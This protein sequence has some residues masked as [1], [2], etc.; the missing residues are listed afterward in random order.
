MDLEVQIFQKVKNPDLYI[1][2]RVEKRTKKDKERGYVRGQQHLNEKQVRI[3][4]KAKWMNGLWWQKLF[5]ESNYFLVRM[6]H[7]NLQVMH[8]VTTALCEVMYMWTRLYMW[9]SPERIPHT[10]LSQ[11][12]DSQRRN[13]P[14]RQR[15]CFLEKEPFLPLQYTN[16]PW[17]LLSMGG[18]FRYLYGIQWRVSSCSFKSHWSGRYT[19][20]YTY[21]YCRGM[22]FFFPI[23]FVQILEIWLS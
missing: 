19:Q 17:I 21:K 6:L 16:S 9:A 4:H 13:I 11:N 12:G 8:K 2:W 1:T 18:R 23:F 14:P 7:H 22:G 3:S 5:G 15:Q 20:C 10:Q